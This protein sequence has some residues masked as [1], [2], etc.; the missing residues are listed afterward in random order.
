MSSLLSQ[1]FGII[2]SVTVLASL[3]LKNIRTVLV[4]QVICNIFGALSFL[5]IG[6]VSACSIYFVAV[7][8]SAL[9]LIYNLCKKE[10][11]KFWTWVFAAAF[12]LCSIATFRVPADVI[13]MLAAISCALAIAQKKASVYR[14]IMLVNGGL[15]ITFDLVSGAYGML[16]AHI[17]TLLSALVGIVR[18]DIGLFKRKDTE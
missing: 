3:Q 8:E 1:V 4:F 2:A 14:I 7:T 6:S 9:F 18:M 10:A 17:I 15:W 5:V 11:P 12:V 16:P 13:S